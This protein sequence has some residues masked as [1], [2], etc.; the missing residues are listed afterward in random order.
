MA[1]GIEEIVLRRNTM[2]DKYKKKWSTSLAIKETQIK[3][4]PRFHL[5]PV[6]LAIIKKTNNKCW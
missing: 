4:I 2:A 6:K 3:T 5:I 1:K